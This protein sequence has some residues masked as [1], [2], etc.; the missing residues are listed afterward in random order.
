MW[1]LF[2]RNSSQPNLCFVSHF[3]Q[4]IAR[5]RSL[6]QS[7]LRTPLSIYRHC[8]GSINNITSVDIESTIRTAAAKVYN[9]DPIR[10]RKTLAAWSSHSVRVGACTLLYSKGFSEMEIKYLLRWKS[11][12]F[13]TYLCNLSVTS[14]RQ[15]EAIN[16]ISEIPNFV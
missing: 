9:L 16:D 5:H 8:D 11:N 13:M 1:K 10:H 2:T 7:C 6:T 12:A 3:L 14:R 4:I 15:N